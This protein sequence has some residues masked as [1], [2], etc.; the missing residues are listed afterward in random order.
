MAKLQGYVVV[1]VAKETGRKTRISIPGEN[2]GLEEGGDWHREDDAYVCG[3]IFIAFC[4]GFDAVLSFG[5]VEDNIRG[6][7]LSFRIQDPSIK[8]VSVTEDGDDLDV[9]LCFRDTDGDNY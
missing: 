7:E 3:F 5:L 9:S 6:Y 2:F 4:D 1:E 8:S